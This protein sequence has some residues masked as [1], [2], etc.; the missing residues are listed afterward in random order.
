MAR[1]VTVVVIDDVDGS[2]NASTV[3]FGLD[4]VTYAIDLGEKNRAK[5]ERD[6]KPFI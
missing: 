4:S 1:N 3:S 5:L 6:L 2:G